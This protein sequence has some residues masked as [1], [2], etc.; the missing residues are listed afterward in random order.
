MG[1]D[2]AVG[3]ENGVENG[4]ETLVSTELQKL[5]ETEKN[6]QGGEHGGVN[7]DRRR[8]FCSSSF[9]KSSNWCM[10]PALGEISLRQD[11]TI[12]NAASNVVFRLYMT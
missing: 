6:R 4:E 5:E 12:S 2:S 7:C 8:L 3:D 10:N 1:L 9:S 11:L